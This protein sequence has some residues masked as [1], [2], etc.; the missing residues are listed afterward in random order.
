MQ[1]NIINTDIGTIAIRSSHGYIVGVK[2]I[3]YKKTKIMDK[4]L[5]HD[6]QNYFNKNSTEFISKYKLTGT[7]FQRQVWHEIMKIPYGETRT[8]GEIAV[9]IGKP[10]AYRAVANACGKK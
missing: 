2:F 5:A 4:I 8:Y 3:Q 9:A 1:K 6:F 7:K 10:N